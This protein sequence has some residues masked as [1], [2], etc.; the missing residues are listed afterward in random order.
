[1]WDIALAENLGTTA[2]DVR[3]N[4][5]YWDVLRYRLWTNAKNAGSKV[6]A[7]RQRAEQNQANT[8]MRTRGRGRRR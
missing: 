3:R 8:R 2:W 7:Q 1:M 5:T 4:A 6:S